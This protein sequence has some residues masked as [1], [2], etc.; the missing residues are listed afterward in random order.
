MLSVILLLLVGICKRE[1]GLG[2]RRREDFHSPWRWK[3]QS[4]LLVILFTSPKHDDS[5]ATISYCSCVQAEHLSGQACLNWKT[6]QN[7]TAIGACRL[8]WPNH[9]YLPLSLVPK[10]YVM[11]YHCRT[12]GIHIYKMARAEVESIC[13]A[14]C[15][16]LVDPC[17]ISYI[18][19]HSDRSY[20]TFPRIRPVYETTWCFITSLN[21]RHLSNGQLCARNYNK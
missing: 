12:W 19:H 14:M 5:N 7:M 6:H 21:A 18:L 8:D 4:L 3:M 9:L 11:R 16:S 2:S 15:S 20:C 10:S 13:W 17:Q 1:F